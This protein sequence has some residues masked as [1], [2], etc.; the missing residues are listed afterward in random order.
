MIMVLRIQS[1]LDTMTVFKEF[2]LPYRL[3]GFA[4][5]SS[6]RI[7]TKKSS[8]SQKEKRWI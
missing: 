8:A 3:W 4:I 6:I 1:D 2:A 7:K 5:N